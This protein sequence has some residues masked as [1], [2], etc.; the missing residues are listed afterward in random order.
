MAFSPA[1]ELRVRELGSRVSKAS[2]LTTQ[3]GQTVT[4]SCKKPSPSQQS[5]LL[6]LN[7]ETL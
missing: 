5:L 7:K 1:V 3:K 4:P 6:I 2:L